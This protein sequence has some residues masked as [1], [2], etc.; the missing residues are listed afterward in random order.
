MRCP[1]CG[2]EIEEGADLCLECGSPLVDTPAA[3]VA[4]KDTSQDKKPTTRIVTGADPDVAP[5]TPKELAEKPVKAPFQVPPGAKKTMR[6]KR[7]A[8]AEEPEPVRCPAC[9]AP[10]RAARCPA[11]GT[12]LRPDD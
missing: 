11:D 4:R 2:S 7:S 3:R 6:A 9:G 10:S 12:L 1:E 5:V 8:R